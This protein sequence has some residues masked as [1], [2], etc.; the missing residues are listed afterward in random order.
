M[1]ARAELHSADRAFP[2]KDAGGAGPSQLMGPCAHSLT[3]K[4]NEEEKAGSST[5]A[6]LKIMVKGW[7][8]QALCL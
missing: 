6:F 3:E 5:S 2:V 7:K 8:D 1:S 4:P